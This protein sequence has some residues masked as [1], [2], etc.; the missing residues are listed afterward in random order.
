MKKLLLFMIAC[1][2]GL[3][4]TVRAQETIVIGET[5]EVVSNLPLDIYNGC[6]L[7]QQMYLADEI[8]HTSGTITSLAVK[9]YGEVPYTGT[10]DE[11]NLNATFERKGKNLQHWHHNRFS[12]RTGYRSGILYG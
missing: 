6:G 4:G 3:F 5:T 10:L 2:L 7:S 12:L 11:V 1:T 9:F 8:S